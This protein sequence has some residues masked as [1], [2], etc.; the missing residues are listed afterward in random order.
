LALAKYWSNTGQTLVKHWSNTGQTLVKLVNRRALSREVKGDSEG[1]LKG[2]RMR[3]GENGPG[4]EAAACMLHCG[5]GFI[6][7]FKWENWLKLK[8]EDVIMIMICSK[9]RQHTSFQEPRVKELNLKDTKR[10]V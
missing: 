1:G 6:F 9:M 10:C 4:T 8:P 2:G 3:W 7:V 5:A